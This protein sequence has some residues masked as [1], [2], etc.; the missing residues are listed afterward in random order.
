METLTLDVVQQAIAKTEKNYESQKTNAIAQIHAIK[1]AYDKLKENGVEGVGELGI[2][3][4]MYGFSITV[5]D[6]TQWGKIH[7]AVGK[8]QQYD[9]QPI[10]DGR[11]NKVMVILTPEQ[12]GL[13]YNLKFKFERKLT[14]KDKCKVITQVSKQKVVVCSI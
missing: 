12:K 7:K 3:D 8:L 11:T 4:L 6:S 13:H 9:K 1:E 2:Y 5:N 14:K 10:G